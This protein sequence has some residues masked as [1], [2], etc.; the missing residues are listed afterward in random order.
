[1]P[2]DTLDADEQTWLDDRLSPP[3]FQFAFFF[4]LFVPLFGAAVASMVWH[5]AGSGP[6]AIAVG[7]A[8]GGVALLY[9]PFVGTMRRLGRENAAPD[10]LLTWTGEARR[11]P[12]PDGAP[13]VWIGEHRV[14]LPVGWE[15]RVFANE[16]PLTARGV[17]ARVPD[18]PVYLLDVE[19]R[20][21]VR[22]EVPL[23]LVRYDAPLYYF[24]LAGLALVANFAAS[25]ACSYSYVGADGHLFSAL[26]ALCLAYG[27][28]VMQQNAAISAR[29]SAAYG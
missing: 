11:A 7:A 8:F 15:G 17:R 5:L 26:T 2:S 29:I 20:C 14:V 13:D 1:M 23:G 3:A 19:G 6:L 25:P 27:A 4:L 10:E 24:V 22:G 21:S 18:A 16:G 28:R 9:F 12:A